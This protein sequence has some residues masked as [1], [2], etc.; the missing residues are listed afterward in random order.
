[1]AEACPFESS[2]ADKLRTQ[3]SKRLVHGSRRVR[4]YSDWSPTP[5][6]AFSTLLDLAVTCS[7]GK[8]CYSAFR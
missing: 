5:E 7:V 3:S 2:A 8:K 6:D 1:M 4:A